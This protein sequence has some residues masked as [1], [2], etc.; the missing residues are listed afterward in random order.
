MLGSITAIPPSKE[1]QITTTKEQ[2]QKSQFL[3]LLVAQLKGQDPM[4]PM[5]GTE[6]VAQLAQFSSLEELINIRE[7]MEKVHQALGQQNSPDESG[8]AD[9]DPAA[10][11]I[12]G[13]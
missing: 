5:D 1:L 13:Q 6:F 4:N 9:G 12:F 10:S 7:V 11:Q 3:Q 8:N 2:E